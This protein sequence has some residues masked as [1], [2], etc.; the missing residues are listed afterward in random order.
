MK[1]FSIIAGLLA[2]LLFGVATPFSKM[3]QG[4]LN[5]FQLA[6]LLYLGAGVT[7]LP[8][9]LGNRSQLRKL[10]GADRVWKTLGIVFFGGFLGPLL[11]MLGLRAAN[12]SSVSIWLNLE[13]VAT[14][15]LGVLLFRERMD[16]KTLVAVA[17]TL[18]AG[19]LTTMGE[20]HSGLFSGLLIAGAC[21]CWGMDNHLTA[22]TEGVSPQAVTMLKG[23]VAG[24][25][26]FAIGCLLSEGSLHASSVVFALLIGSVSYG[27][28]IVLYVKSAQLLGATR[29]QILFSTAP[30][31]G[32]LLSYLI[33]GEP[34]KCAHMEALILLAMAVFIISRQKQQM[35]YR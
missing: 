19:I 9:V 28:S 16:K 24:S 7:M 35:G 4:G 2:G 1:R 13:L 32:I 21:L 30:L 31:W 34:F 27:M 26:N 22:L 23:L 17:L 25:V 29:S 6:G 12:A 20:G 5:A 18:L 11:L 14:A 10:F 3:L 8:F 15:I 33:L